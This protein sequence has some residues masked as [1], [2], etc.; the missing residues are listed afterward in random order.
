MTDDDRGPHRAPVLAHGGDDD[1]GPEDGDVPDPIPEADS[2]ATEEAWE[3]A[4]SM[5]GEAP[6]G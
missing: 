3:E 2:A 1:A 5:E 4:E 6:T